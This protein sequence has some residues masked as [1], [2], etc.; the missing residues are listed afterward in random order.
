MSNSRISGLSQDSGTSRFQ[1]GS[2]A[3]HVTTPVHTMRV[4]C[5]SGLFGT[6]LLRQLHFHTVLTDGYRKRKT[7]QKQYERYFLSV[8]RIAQPIQCTGAV[9]LSH[10]VHYGLWALA[11]PD[12]RMRKMAMAVACCRRKTVEQNAPRKRGGTMGGVA[13]MIFARVGVMVE[14]FFLVTTTSV[15]GQRPQ[16]S[17]KEAVLCVWVVCKRSLTAAIVARHVKLSSRH[18]VLCPMELGRGREWASCRRI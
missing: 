18:H 12:T 10:K 16:S 9:S 3:R 15:S 14:R 17:S 6:N 2:V 11:L 7:I 4:L 13:A 1:T 5:G 8:T